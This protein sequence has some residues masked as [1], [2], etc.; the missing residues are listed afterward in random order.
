MKIF[1]CAALV[2]ALTAAGGAANAHERRA[3]ERQPAFVIVS[4][5]AAA[6]DAATGLRRDIAASLS[7]FG[8]RTLVRNEQPQGLIG[9]AADKVTIIRFRS[10]AAA[11]RWTQSDAARDIGDALKKAGHATAL[12]VSGQRHQRRDR[13]DDD[14]DVP[15]RRWHHRH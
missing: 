1:A 5:D 14:R 2:L 13:D 4:L 11:K 9:E 6:A 10:V 7:P 8:G 12:L 15:H 3:H